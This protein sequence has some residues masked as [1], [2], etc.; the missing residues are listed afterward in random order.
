MGLQSAR[1]H[2]ST[3]SRKSSRAASTI[4]TRAASR[5]RGPRKKRKDIV[6]ALR[7]RKPREYRTTI[8]KVRYGNGN[9]NPEWLYDG[10]TRYV[11]ECDRS[12]I[13]AMEQ[14]EYMQWAINQV[15]HDH[16]DRPLLWMKEQGIFTESEIGE[17][18]DLKEKQIRKRLRR[19]RKELEELFELRRRDC[20][21][22]KKDDDKKEKEEC[23]KR[24]AKNSEKRKLG[25]EFM[26]RWREAKLLAGIVLPTSQFLLLPATADPPEF[27]PTPAMKAD[28]AWHLRYFAITPNS[29]ITVRNEK[30]TPSFKPKS[31]FR[32]RVSALAAVLVSLS[33]RCRAPLPPP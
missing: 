1:T 17:V 2:R 27:Q 23:S 11:L 3:I 32:R 5:F 33:A 28:R 9:G 21:K 22:E 10:N 12:G 26:A 18:L 16:K 25:E 4:A 6:R 30:V 7:K 20:D 8:Y 31:G 29:R 24:V 14:Q 19:M 15:C 13:A